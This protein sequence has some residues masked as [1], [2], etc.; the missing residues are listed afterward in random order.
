MKQAVHVIQVTVHERR[1]N[2]VA[3]LVEHLSGNLTLG[4]LLLALRSLGGAYYNGVSL[5]FV[6]HI[7]TCEDL[8]H[9]LLD[10]FGIDIHL[11]ACVDGTGVVH[12]RALALL[13]EVGNGGLHCDAVEPHRNGL[14]IHCGTC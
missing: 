6:G 7:L 13:F 1:L 2:G 11:L 4:L 14:G 12:N 9:C 3:V 10:G 5:N 8:R